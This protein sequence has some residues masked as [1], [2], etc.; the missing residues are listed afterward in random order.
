MPA[1]PPA[2]LIKMSCTY[3]LQIPHHPRCPL[4]AEPQPYCY[5]SICGHGIYDGEEYVRNDDGEFVHLDCLTV[6]EMVEFLGHKVE[7]VDSDFSTS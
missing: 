7:I 1:R 6:R 5:C 4:A 3:C 2:E